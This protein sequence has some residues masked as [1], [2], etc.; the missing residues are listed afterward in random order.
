MSALPCIGWLKAGARSLLWRW[1]D[2]RLGS[3]RAGIRVDARPA[4]IVAPHQ[5]DESFGCGG[6]IA[7]KRELG[8]PVWVVFL[9]D[10]GLSYG[11]DRLPPGVQVARRRREALEALDVLGVP[12]ASVRFLDR[13]DGTLAELRGAGR[14]TLLDELG[15]ILAAAA[16][17]EVYVTYRRDGHPD[18]EA[19][20]VLV[21]EAIGRS[22]LRPEV[23]EYPVWSRYDPRVLDFASPDFASLRRLP[24]A[25]V[26]ERKRRAIACHRSQFEPIPP[27]LRGGLPEGFLERLGTGEEL[28][29]VALDADD[30]GTARVSA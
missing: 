23:R 15:S 2:A 26:L 7:M 27:D 8:A 4:L 11:A 20:S 3:G 18:H 1:L 6:L 21:R 16:P 29:F 22:G 30:R 24:I 10:G 14:A 12:R 19:A 9:T 5:D 25:T 28:Y 17:A 13:A